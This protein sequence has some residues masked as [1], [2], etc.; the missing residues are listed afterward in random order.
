[1]E[2]T[3]PKIFHIHIDA[4]H[5]PKSLEK[6]VRTE[7]GFYDHHFTGHPDGYRHF[8][9]NA[10]LTRKL[11]TYDEF[12]TG[13]IALEDCI[14]GDF[15]G[16]FEGEFIPVDEA[17][18][19]RPYNDSI[20]VP[21]EI[22]RRRLRGTSDEQFRQTELHLVMDKDAS[23]PRLI[24][25]LLDAGLYGA[26]LPKKD[27]NAV[28]LTM[29]GFRKDICPLYKTLKEYLHQAGGIMKGTL[30]EERAIRHKLIGIIPEQLP[31][32]AD[33]ITYSQCLR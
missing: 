23:D 22:K 3:N 8:E 32:I 5:M 9:P 4:H 7:L 33:T 24:K 27:H 1:M 20:P 21:F 11:T 2:K 14:G 30:K 16:Y 26:Y 12:E 18:P 6:H 29:Q 13:W 25:K 15:V 10:H 17:I 31:E 19:E 28:V